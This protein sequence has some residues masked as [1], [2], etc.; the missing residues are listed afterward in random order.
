MLNY[1]LTITSLSLFL[2]LA[3][4]SNN[5]EELYTECITND[6]RYSVHIKPYIENQCLSCH[7]TNLPSGNVSYSNFEGLK[8]SV[9]DGSFLGSIQHASPFAAMPPSGS[10]TDDCKISQIQAWIDQGAEKN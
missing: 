7:N 4:T 8:K 6:I 3:C 5:E 10:M 1:K 9:N 2:L